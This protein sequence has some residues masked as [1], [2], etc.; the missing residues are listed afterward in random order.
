MRVR[1]S[2]EGKGDQPQISI[3]RTPAKPESLDYMNVSVT[4]VSPLGYGESDE[5]IVSIILFIVSLLS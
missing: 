1:R 4:S 2:G 5:D 3:T